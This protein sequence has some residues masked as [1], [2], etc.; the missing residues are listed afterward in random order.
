M[1]ENAES[2]PPELSFIVYENDADLK[3]PRREVRSHVARAQHRRAR[4]SHQGASKGAQR[5]AG[6]DTRAQRNHERRTTAAVEVHGEVH[7]EEKG[8]PSRASKGPC[9]L[10]AEGSRARQSAR[11]VPIAATPGTTLPGVSTAIPSA[12]QLVQAGGVERRVVR[13]SVLDD[14]ADKMAS[15]LGRLQLD[16]PTVMEQ[17]KW[18]VW[19]QSPDWQRIFAPD[20]PPGEGSREMLGRLSEDPALIATA[21]LI[22]TSH[23]VDIL[24]S[25]LDTLISR[26][27]MDLRGFVTRTINGALRDPERGT[28]DAVIGAVLLLATDEGLQGQIESYHAHMRGLVQMI[29]IRGGLISLNRRQ[30][31]LESLVKWQDANV[32]VA[33]GNKQTYY[34]MCDNPSL[35]LPEVTPCLSLW[36]RTD[37]VS[38][39]KQLDE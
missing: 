28:C 38:V 14:P 7:G 8:R 10:T 24:Y 6:K 30:L 27:I 39:R 5:A 37:G 34:S 4:K 19:A 15:I 1:A 25:R 11:R 12:A 13:E 3:Q 20:M 29:N 22:G 18:I 32:S 33:M 21:A 16:F 2:S 35:D 26:C 23:I 36:P 31:Y 9:R 17:Y